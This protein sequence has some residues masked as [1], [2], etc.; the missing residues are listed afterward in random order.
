MTKIP[1]SIRGA[2]ASSTDPSTW[3]TYK[4]A[5]E[6]LR[7][8]GFG[9]GIGI[10]F[11]PDQTLLGIDIDHVLED[12]K[13][14]HE[15]GD[16]IKS[17]IKEAKTYTEISPSGTG[18]HLY[19]AISDGPLELEA[20]RHAPFEAYTSGRFFT[21]SEVPFG[22]KRPIRTVHKAEALRLLGI[23][24]YPWAKAETTG[25]AVSVI[26]LGKS[27]LEDADILKRMFDSKNGADIKKLYQGD[28]SA[29]LNDKGKPNLSSADAALLAH[30][31]FWTRHDKEQMDR[32]WLASPL[33]QR[34]KTQGRI[35]YRVRSIAGAIKNCKD[36]YRTQEERIK[37]E[38]GIDFL[39]TLN[40]QKDKVITQNT[41]NISRILRFHPIFKGRIRYDAFTNTIE[42]REG[43][44]PSLPWRPFEDND[45]I[46]IQTEISIHFEFFQKVGK[47]MVF[48]AIILVAKECTHD[49]AIEFV[50][51]VE[52]DQ[53]DRLAT[54][55]CKVYGV[56]DNAYHRAVGSNWLKGMVKRIMEPGCKFDYVMV[57]EGPQG[58]KKST[59]L[60]VLAKMPN[61]KNGHVET[62]M[63][64]DSKDFFMQMFGKFIME[65][66][67]GETLSR[68]E[69][70]KLKAII[71]TQVDKL[72]LPYARMSLDVPRRCAFAMTTNQDE[73][74]KDE[75]GN[76]RWLPV[77]VVREE[78]DIE[79]LE[80]NRDQLIAEAWARLQAG[81]SVHEFPKD[82]TA[83]QQEARRVSDPNED[84]ISEWYFDEHFMTDHKRAE[85]ITAQMAYQ[86]ALNGNFGAM[87]KFEEMAIIDVFKR[88]LKLKKVRRQVG[89]TQSWRWIPE[90][91]VDLALELEE[92]EDPF[93]E[94]SLSEMEV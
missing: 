60:S 47:D 29:Y 91:S 73:Y 71:T 13:I 55:L 5:K 80:T 74:L 63:G 84:R 83:A 30:L 94:K 3:S 23:I 21:W 67:E 9:S 38:T 72:R 81:E 87:R 78:A 58:A 92:A 86:Q 79:W 19:L 43:S 2:K 46:A 65:F 44:D 37:E 56:E 4:E 40:A 53:E 85:G 51:A 24:G 68:T 22:S 8:N 12:S 33:G 1:Y 45:A 41:E 66:S 17:L 31:A 32:I 35:D 14:K 88:V 20:N 39:F 49:S 64:V 16:A 76:R 15:K 52:W 7:D 70:K 75:T 6:A 42:Y 93:S 27:L 54:W 57:L 50:K 18:L 36:V 89:G 77:R 61:G 10:V 48:D 34:E 28:A 82:E 59:S 62:T 69:I 11:T 26:E 25:P 90:G